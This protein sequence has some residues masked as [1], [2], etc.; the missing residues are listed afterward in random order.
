MSLKDQMEQDQK[1]EQAKKGGSWFKFKEG[2]NKVRVLTQ[3][4]AIYEDYKLGMCYTGCNFQGSIKYLTYI[5][6]YADKS[7]KLMKI[8]YTVFQDIANFEQDED[9]KFTS[10]PMPYSLNIRAS[11]AG[12]K[13]VKYSTIPSPN[14]NEVPTNVIESISKMK[15]VEEIIEGMKKK[16]EE[17]H[18]SDGTWDKLHQDMPEVE[19]P[20]SAKRV[21]YPTAEQE[22]INPQDIPW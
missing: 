6:D 13:E 10:F 15:G 5:Y 2:D 8:P 1:S 21:P 4:L 3:P 14:R 17:K 20:E 18:K 12:T 7:I 19:T 9:Y 11:N 22:G 16:N